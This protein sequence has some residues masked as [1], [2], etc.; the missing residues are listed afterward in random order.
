[1]WDSVEG[2]KGASNEAGGL[3]SGYEEGEGAGRGS[4]NEALRP[5]KWPRR[6]KAVDRCVRAQTNVAAAAKVLG[7]VG[8]LRYTIALWGEIRLF[9]S[10]PTGSVREG[11][12]VKPK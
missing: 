8:D 4:S 6:E 3:R 12:R 10:S 1:M 2:G 7:R 11:P 9:F 5:A